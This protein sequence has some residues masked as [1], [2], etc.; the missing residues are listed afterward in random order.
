MLYVIECVGIHRKLQP[1]GN[2]KSHIQLREEEKML[3]FTV[4]YV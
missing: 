2:K 4:L 3:S 1:V